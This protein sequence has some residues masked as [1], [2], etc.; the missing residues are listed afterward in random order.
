MA[1]AKVRQ[2]TRE[3]VAFEHVFGEAAYVDEN[4]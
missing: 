1:T 4:N 3:Q 2:D